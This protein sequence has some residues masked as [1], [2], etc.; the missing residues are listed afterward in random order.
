MDG[1]AAGSERAASIPPSRFYSTYDN[2]H[3][4]VEDLENWKKKKNSCCAMR[5]TISSNLMFCKLLYFDRGYILDWSSKVYD[6]SCD[7]L[8]C[9]KVSTPIHTNDRCS[10]PQNTPRRACITGCGLLV[11]LQSLHITPAGYC[12]AR[13]ASMGSRTHAHTHTTA[14]L[15]P[16]KNT[17]Q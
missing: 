10:D 2:A 12:V 5:S 1:V 17:S 9:R 13:H 11:G 4:F 6:W 15:T 8:G 7:A 14:V 16:P 3:V